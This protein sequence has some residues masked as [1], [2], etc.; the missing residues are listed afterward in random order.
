[1]NLTRITRITSLFVLFPLT[2]AKKMGA[3]L[4]TTIGNTRPLFTPKGDNQHRYWE[5][6]N[7]PH[8]KIIV[9]TGPA[10]TGKTMMA[11]TQAI[12]L[13]QSGKTDKIIITRPTVSADDEEIGFL[14]GSLTHKME[15]W[16][17]PMYDIFLG[18]YSKVQLDQLLLN[19]KIEICPLAFM[20]GRTFT[21]SF[22][23]ADEMQNSSPNQMKMLT[24][25]I[26]EH[27]HMVITGDPNQSDLCTRENGLTDLTGRLAR[28][29][30][31]LADPQNYPIQWIQLYAHDVKRSPV[32]QE[33]LSL[34][35]GSPPLQT[36][37]IQ[38]T[39]PIQTHETQSLLAMNTTTTL[40]YKNTTNNTNNT[41]TKGDAA[42][43]P[44][45]DYVRWDY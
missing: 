32:V 39:N 30:P 43:I 8:C 1:M 12:T 10:G 2:P 3:I 23:I 33:I 37:P 6:L 44:L 16:M 38:T 21:R 31:N 25:R 7:T 19:Q 24:T 40:S 29:S 34:Y 26:G 5:L 28:L 42:M 22:I 11:C 18:H 36:H 4:G 41:N 20:R 13:F 27:S 15:P 35:E 9:A 17:K 45:R 14:P